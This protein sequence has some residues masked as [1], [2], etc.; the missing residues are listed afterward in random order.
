MAKRTLTWNRYSGRFN[1]EAFKGGQN[2]LVAFFFGRFNHPQFRQLL[3]IMNSEG[4]GAGRA[5]FLPIAF[6]TRFEDL[7]EP[8][9]QV[10]A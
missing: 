7:D 2:F 3:I 5:L 1:S 9:S 10:C 4:T 6:C 8:Q